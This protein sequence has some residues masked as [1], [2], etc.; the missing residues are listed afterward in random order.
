MYNQDVKTENKNKEEIEKIKKNIS[1]LTDKSGLV[2]ENAR[3]NLVKI[4]IP[5]VHY[6]EELTTDARRIARWEAIKTLAEIQH[7]VT[8]S[9]LINALE[10]QSEDV[11]WIA[12]EG[13]AD[14]GETGFIT[15]L[16]A[17][18]KNDPTILLLN[19][20]HHILTRLKS[21]MDKPI[22]NEI[23]QIIK[24][25]DPE[26]K[27]PLKIMSYMDKMSQDKTINE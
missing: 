8:A 18:K 6:L 9:F 27:L 24:G 5:A 21:S 25:T 20:A 12:A 22:I 15:T 4:G 17:L 23:L 1:R 26:L 3:K 10:D 7:P 14:L 11:R 2:R 19:G 16:N 13:L